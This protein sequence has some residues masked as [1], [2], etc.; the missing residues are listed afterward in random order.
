MT[1]EYNNQI[2]STFL[3]L[4]VEL[5]SEKES[6]FE[7]NGKQFEFKTKKVNP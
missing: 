3:S 5:N 6:D 7:L 2:F 1:N 4:S